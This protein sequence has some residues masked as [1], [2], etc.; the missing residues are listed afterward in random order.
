M[1]NNGDVTQSFG[2]EDYWVVKLDPAGNID[3]QKSL[4]GSGDDIANSITQTS[5]GGYIVAGSASS[6]DGDVSFNHGSTA[7]SDMWIVKSSDHTIS[8]PYFE[9]EQ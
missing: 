8:N 2:N 1:S 7:F 5:D 4:G 3:W 9:L 6:N